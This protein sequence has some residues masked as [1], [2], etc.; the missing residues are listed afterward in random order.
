MAPRHHYHHRRRGLEVFLLLLHHYRRPPISQFVCVSCPI[1]WSFVGFF[2]FKALCPNS[3]PPHSV[4]MVWS[5]RSGL[6]ISAEIHFGAPKVGHP[7]F[8]ITKST[9][10]NTQWNETICDLIIEQFEAADP[11]L[12][13]LI[14]IV[15]RVGVSA[16]SVCCKHLF[17]CLQQCCLG[18]DKSV[19][20]GRV[21]TFLPF[22]SPGANLISGALIITI[23][24]LIA[25]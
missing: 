24:P 25:F 19:S 2:I 18:P 14:F 22:A 11:A 3:V 17:D 7:I 15:Y 13:Q 12:C 9:N 16:L 21:S 10:T 8:I 1:I 23:L 6:T 4:S 20:Q 5:G